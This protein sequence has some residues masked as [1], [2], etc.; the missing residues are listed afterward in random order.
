MMM[1]LTSSLQLLETAGHLTSSSPVVVQLE[2]YLSSA[3]TSVECLASYPQL[4]NAFIK[5]ISALSSMAAVEHPFSAGGHQILCGK[6]CKLSNN[7]FDMFV[8]LRDFESST[9]CE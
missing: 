6:C 5:A 8:F 1:M 3:S 2:N 9:V 7:H 4:T